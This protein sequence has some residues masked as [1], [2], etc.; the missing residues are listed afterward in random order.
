LM[1][2]KVW[3]Q[4]QQESLRDFNLSLSSL[5]TSA[6]NLR[7]QSSFNSYSATSADPSSVSVS[8]TA[9]AVSGS[10]KVEVMSVAS[11]AKLNSANAIEKEPGVAAKSTDLI[12]TSGKITVNGT[13]TPNIVIEIRL[14]I[15]R[16]SHPFLIA[17][18]SIVQDN[19]GK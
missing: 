19:G 15:I 12:G 1:Q 6:S 14:D 8:T 13:G 10:Y 18:K 16:F 5:R 4:W 11:P 2:K 7:L 17:C 3:T 9:N